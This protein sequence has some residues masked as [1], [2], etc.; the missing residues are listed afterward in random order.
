MKLFI[1]DIRNVPDASWIIARSYLAAI[2]VILTK[3]VMEISFDHDLGDEIHWH[4]GYDVMAFVEE[5]VYHGQ[6]KA[7]VIHIHS[8]NMGARKRME[9]CRDSIYK[10][11]EKHDKKIYYLESKY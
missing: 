9:L 2:E 4:T 5:L 11:A 6:L 7:P 3:K 1:D 8:A 10:M